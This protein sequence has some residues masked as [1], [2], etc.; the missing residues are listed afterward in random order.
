MLRVCSSRLCS[1]VT[2]RD[3]TE[4]IPDVGSTA[5]CDSTAA[6]RETSWPSVG[7]AAVR[8]ATSIFPPTGRS[9]AGSS[10]SRT[11]TSPGSTSC[12]MVW[13]ASA[14]EAAVRIDVPA[15]GTNPAARHSG[16]RVLA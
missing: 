9:L 11:A 15:H 8:A 3:S 2:A 6:V 16:E 1:S 14:S 10:S 4:G 12:A 13:T 7:A 5:T